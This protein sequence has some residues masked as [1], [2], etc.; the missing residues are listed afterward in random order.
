[1]ENIL[2]QTKPEKMYS[3]IELWQESNLSTKEFYA[4]QNISQPVFYY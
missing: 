2:K 1:M 4:E 3:F